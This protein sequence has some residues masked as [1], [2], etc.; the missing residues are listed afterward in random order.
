LFFAGSPDANQGWMEY[1]LRHA[2][3]PAAF[4][5]AV[6]SPELAAALLGWA[7]AVVAEK[8]SPTSA[9][10]HLAAALAVARLPW[11]WDAGDK[12]AVAR[13][14][15]ILL[16]HTG[17][18]E[19]SSE[20]PV[21]EAWERMLRRGHALLRFEE[22]T[23]AAPLAALRTRIRAT[24][25]LPGDLLWQGAAGYCVVT[26]ATPRLE[27]Q[28]VPV[29]RLQNQSEESHFVASYTMP[30]GS[31]LEE[32]VLPLSPGFSTE[33]RR[34]LCEFLD[35]LRSSLGAESATGKRQG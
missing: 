10:F 2:D 22:A 9:R 16:A 21:S 26:K 25:L 35:E 14:L 8:T 28:K 18:P 23:K 5:A 20:A 19:A 31:L 34:V 30:I 13:E 15:Q 24:E 33:P 1:R 4:L 3:D 6:R 27:G 17:M 7:F 32:A 12:A 29:L 11:L